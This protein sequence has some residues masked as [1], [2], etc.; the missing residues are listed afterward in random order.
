M[1]NTFDP[2]ASY[3]AAPFDPNAAYT[4]SSPAQH[5]TADQPP[6]TAAPGHVGDNKI[7]GIKADTEPT[8]FRDRATRWAQSVMDDIKYGTDTTGVGSVLK[9]MGAHG[10]YNGNSKEV[11]DFMGSLPL[12]L[13]RM[14]KGGAEVT[15]H[16]IQGG[17]D[18]IGGAAQAAEIPSLLASPAGAEAAVTTAEKGA[19]AVGRG[20]EAIKAATPAAKIA[21]GA[22]IFKELKS[23]IGEHTVEMTDNLSKALFDIKEAVDTGAT[24]PSPINKFVTRIADLEQPP[25][26][27]SEARSF[28]SNIGDLAASDKMAMNDKGRRLLNQFRAAL[29]DTIAAT[30]E[31]A[32]KLHDYRTAMSTFAQG[33]KREEQLEI[34]KE[35][36][37][38]IALKTLKLG[39]AGAAA[40]AGWDIYS[41]R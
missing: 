8:G 25:L 3:S 9:K 40:K 33:K 19:A 21:K 31:N 34:A 20:V 35:F 2:N 11:G 29:G 36:A 22:D 27:Y 28:Y 16:P 4:A 32:S 39:A 1:G 14:T 7:E 24:L 26:T 5:P 10:V 37:K 12:G 15:E 6:A 17:K 30:A 13:A 41:A 18:I 38:D 23:T